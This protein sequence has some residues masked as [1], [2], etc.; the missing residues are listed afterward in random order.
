MKRTANYLI[1]LFIFIVVATAKAQTA[2]LARVK[3]IF[4]LNFIKYSDHQAANSAE[5]F[6]VGVYGDEKLAQ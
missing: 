4:I 1:L 6:V 5:A 3:A 2:E